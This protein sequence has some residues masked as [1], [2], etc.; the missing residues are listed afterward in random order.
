MYLG[1]VLAMPGIGC[2][3]NN[4]W[5]LVLTIP[6]IAAFHFYMIRPEELY[7]LEKFGDEYKEYMQRVRRWL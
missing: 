6:L 3:F 2:A 1:V 4:L 7:L 5:F